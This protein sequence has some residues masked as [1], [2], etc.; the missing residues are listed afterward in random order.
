MK[1][2]YSKILHTNFSKAYELTRHYI[3][4]E[5]FDIISEIDLTDIFREKLHVDFREYRILCACNPSMVFKALKT[6]N[7]IGTML[8]C[9]II[10]QEIGH[11]LIE[12]AAIAP[13]SDLQM[14]QNKDIQDIFLQ[15]SRKLQK[16]IDKLPTPN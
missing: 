6:E 13:E 9:N 14:I 8:P 1:S 5:G 4:E 7:K 2:Y 12:V 16:V 3:E 15:I 10:I 11:R